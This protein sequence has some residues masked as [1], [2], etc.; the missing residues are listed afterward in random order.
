MNGYV[1]SNGGLL[2]L[3]MIFFIFFYFFCSA[4]V[5]DMVYVFGLFFL[6]FSNM[7][8]NILL[9]T[10][11]IR[12]VVVVVLVYVSVILLSLLVSL[13][14]VSTGCNSFFYGLTTL[15]VS[16]VNSQQLSL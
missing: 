12:L 9:L 11:I 15:I 5:Y 13:S 10:N 14:C 6:S 1:S 7:S 3:F 8:I 4:L 2:C 16:F